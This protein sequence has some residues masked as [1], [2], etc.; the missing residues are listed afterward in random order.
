MYYEKNKK[1][2][3][4]IKHNF[5]RKIRFLAAL[6]ALCCCHGA[7]AQQDTAIINT[8]W[9]NYAFDTNYTYSQIVTTLDSLFAMAGYPTGHRL[10]QGP[11]K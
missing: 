5:M 4:K 10:Q 2:V 8:T 7:R 3:N 6:I 9:P 11:S 1:N